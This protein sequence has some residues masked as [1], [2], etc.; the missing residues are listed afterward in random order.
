MRRLATGREFDRGLLGQR[1][2]LEL[3]NGDRIDLPVERWTDGCGQ[4]DAV[5]LDG[6][7][8]PTLDIGCGPGRLTAALARRGVVAL[9]VDS[10][11]TAVRLTQERGAAA[12]R[13]D[14]FQPLPGEGRWHHALLADGNIGIGGDPVVLLD[15]VQELI[16]PDGDVLVE[17]E[18]P[19]HGLRREAV[20]VLSGDAG[21][22]FGWAWVGADA[23]AEVA[24]RSGFRVDWTTSRGHR[25]FAR[26]ERR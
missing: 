13:R 23:V 9:G 3:A 19:G 22:W 5:L 12:L 11:P 21:P 16:S 26:L 8:G 4:G 7:D 24:M 10:S 6:C 14:V 20:R 1:C 18:A 2:S 25:W 15:R 17:V